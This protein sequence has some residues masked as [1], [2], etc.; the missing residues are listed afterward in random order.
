MGM[1]DLQEGFIDVLKRYRNGVK[2]VVIGPSPRFGVISEFLLLSKIGL[3]IE[4]K[5]EL[6]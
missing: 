1:A 3:K 2:K 5:V 6:L 4:R